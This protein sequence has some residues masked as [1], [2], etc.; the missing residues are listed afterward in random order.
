MWKSA[1]EGSGFK[2]RWAVVPVDNGDEKTEH[3][4]LSVLLEG[5]G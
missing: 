2:L 5:I 1:K 4:L 3:F